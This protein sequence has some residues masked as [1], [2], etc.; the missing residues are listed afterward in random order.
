M[1]DPPSAHES[2]QP[3]EFEKHSGSS[4]ARSAAEFLVLLLIGVLF[5]R[6]F[7]AEAYVVPTGSMAPTLLG[8]HREYVCPNCQLR[9]ALG[10]DEDGHTGR[11]ACPNCGQTEWDGADSIESSGDRLLVQKYLYDLR[12]P[13]RWETAV[14]QNPADPRQAYVKRVVGLPGET[15]EIRDGDVYIDGQIAQ[16]AGAAAGVAA[17][18]L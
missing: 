3:G 4:A 16:D 13:R 10:I 9:F 5:A 6:T 15:V 1:S 18:G 8:V 17:A 11:P 2:D 14:F 12:S 7:A